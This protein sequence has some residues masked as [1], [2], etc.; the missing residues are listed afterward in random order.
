MFN[1]RMFVAL[2]ACLAISASS[3]FAGGN[4]GTKKDATL[5]VHNGSSHTLYAFVNVPSQSIQNAVNN[6]QNNPQGILAA[7]NSL[8]GKQISP[9]GTSS[10]SV[11]GGNQQVTVI[12]IETAQQVFVNR[13]IYV[14]PHGTAKINV[15]DI[16]L[17]PAP[18][19]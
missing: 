1:R 5:K 15:D 18:V 12:D 2:A 19:G 3:A 6:N 11:K 10:T 17:P 8:G 14:P 4:G 16:D 9:G 13:A 7:F